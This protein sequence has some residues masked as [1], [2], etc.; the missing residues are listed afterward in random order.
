M[1]AR[2]GREGGER[3]RGGRMGRESGTRVRRSVCGGGWG[4]ANDRE[5]RALRVHVRSVEEVRSGEANMCALYSVCV[6]VCVSCLSRVASLGAGLP[7]QLPR[8]KASTSDAI[9]PHRGRQGLCFISLCERQVEYRRIGQYW[10]EGGRART[11]SIAAHR[12]PTAGGCSA[13][14]PPRGG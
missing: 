1:G 13:A 3:E 5:Q 10:E 11:G 9:R 2:A 14:M 4:A 7:C 8:R 6:C 12:R